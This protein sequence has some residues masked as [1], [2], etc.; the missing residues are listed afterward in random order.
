MTLTATVLQDRLNHRLH[1]TGV[2]GA[3]LSCIRD[4]DIL[5]ACGGVRDRNDGT[6]VDAGTVFDVASL[7][8]PL[9][10]Y[11]VLQ[12]A[13]AGV[14]DLDAPLAA[15]TPPLVAGDARAAAITARHVLSHTGGLPNLR[16][17][18]PLR[19]YF[20]PG[21]RFSYSSVGF[22]Y[23][24]SAL[25]AVTGEP[26]EA[27]AR[28]L[29]FAPLGMA[30]SS[31]EW[32]PRFAGNFVHPHEHDKRTAKH[33]PPGAHASY[34]LHTTAHDYA[35]FVQAALR[36]ERLR[37]ATHRQWLEPVLPA[38]R[39]SVLSLETEAAPTAGS[40]IGWGL[41]WGIE[42]ARG[43]FFQWGKMPGV[44]AFVMGSPAERRAVVL[45]SNSNRGLRLMHDAAQWILPG[46]HAAVRWLQACVSE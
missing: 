43:A 32:Q 11:A 8:K 9:V 44:R 33:Y 31:L 2:A 28:R 37:P 5:L 46:E 14:L 17:S 38:P 29:V 41:G 40:G 36:G 20:A 3:A 25:E 26:L 27:L 15:F 12:L 35:R 10:S 30:S 45:L 21:E 4:D 13:D 23:L 39:D 16:G 22:G 34:S 6:P 24:Q 7:T 1:E 18:E 42:T 19:T